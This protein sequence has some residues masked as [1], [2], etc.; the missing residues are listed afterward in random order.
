MLKMLKKIAEATTA[1]S[2]VNIEKERLRVLKQNREQE[3][4]TKANERQAVK[5]NKSKSRV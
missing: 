1:L 4:A 3:Q 5:K 2:Q